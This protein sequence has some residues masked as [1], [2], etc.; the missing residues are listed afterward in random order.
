MTYQKKGFILF[1]FSTLT[2]LSFQEIRSLM[3]PKLQCLNRYIP[4]PR[5]PISKTEKQFPVYIP[6]IIFMSA[7]TRYWMMNCAEI[8]TSET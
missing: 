8:T 2:E 5:N 3:T 4:Y 1:S 6:N 7:N